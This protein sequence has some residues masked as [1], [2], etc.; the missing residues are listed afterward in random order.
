MALHLLIMGSG[1][2]VLCEKFGEVAGTRVRCAAVEGEY[3]EDLLLLKAASRVSDMKLGGKV[4]A[5]LLVWDMA[6]P[7]STSIFFSM[8]ETFKTN[9]ERIYVCL[10]NGDLN[11]AVLQARDSLEIQSAL[12][13]FA[14]RFI[15]SDNPGGALKSLIRL[16]PRG[17]PLQMDI[18]A[19]DDF[20]REAALRR[21]ARKQVY[22][23]ALKDEVGKSSMEKRFRNKLAETM[24]I[25]GSRIAV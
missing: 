22:S 15:P 21:D 1:S 16:R 12:S 14:E 7:K 20:I 3:D 8:T 19:S 11:S 6:S 10:Q 2:K 24:K 4:D 23:D 13:F 25:L 9:L 17:P 18:L 5:M